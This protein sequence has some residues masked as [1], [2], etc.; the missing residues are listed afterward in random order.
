M[1]KYVTEFLKRG[2][3]AAAGGPAVLAVVYGILGRVGII[4]GL[5]PGEVSMGIL[6]VTLMAFI[7]AGITM[8]YTVES[9][10]LISAILIHAG[11]L[12][13]D[14]LVMYLLNSWIPRDLN[15]IGI[16]TGIFVAGYAI[17]WLI[18]YCCIKAKT[19]KIN[20]KLQSS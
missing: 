18:I 5:S 17:V 1:K 16:F 19:D 13:L 8:I 6:T 2:L 14:Y 10:P 15:A 20:L 3:M 12:Y 4:E 9:L 7:A 11:V